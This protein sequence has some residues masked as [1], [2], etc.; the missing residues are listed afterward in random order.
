MKYSV[1]CCNIGCR[2]TLCERSAVFRRPHATIVLLNAF[3]MLFYQHLR[4]NFG[5][6][7]LVA[8]TDF[9]KDVKVML[10]NLFSERFSIFTSKYFYTGYSHR[11]DDSILQ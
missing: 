10:Q 1:L 6:K 9:F 4:N 7:L 3:T 2:N 11:I 5:L 8:N